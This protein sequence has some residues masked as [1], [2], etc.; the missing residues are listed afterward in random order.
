MNEDVKNLSKIIK[1]PFEIVNGRV[2]FSISTLTE[3]VN[4]SRKGGF[5]AGIAL[6]CGLLKSY[7]GQHSIAKYI[8]NV[9]CGIKTKK[10]LIDSGVDKFDIEKLEEFLE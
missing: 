9:D 7:Y 2:T 3:L 10:E 5:N 8:L 6:V 4:N 1:H